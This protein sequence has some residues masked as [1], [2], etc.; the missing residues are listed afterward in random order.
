VLAFDS[1]NL[2]ASL[3]DNEVRGRRWLLADRLSMGR[4]PLWWILSHALITALLM[5]LGEFL[6]DS[7]SS[8][9]ADDNESTT[10]RQPS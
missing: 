9:P 10:Y 8:S 4:I 2:R 5:H 7:P 3:E 6:H 1:D